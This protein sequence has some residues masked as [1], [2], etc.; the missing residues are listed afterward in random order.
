MLTRVQKSQR[1]FI[2]D[3][4]ASWEFGGV[5]QAK[6]VQPGKCDGSEFSWSLYPWCYLKTASGA[7]QVVSTEISF[8]LPENF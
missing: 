3:A 4:L 8:H 1:Q 5:L 6:G 7:V 2:W